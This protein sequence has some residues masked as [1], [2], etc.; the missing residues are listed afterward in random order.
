M[1]RS[2][3]GNTLPNVFVLLTPSFILLLP[4]ICK[5]HAPAYIL[6]C[7]FCRTAEESVRIV[8]GAEV[9]GSREQEVSCGIELETKIVEKSR[10]IRR[11]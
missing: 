5:V 11:F 6:E 3:L 1:V 7:I 10:T 9:A 8:E 4:I 2:T